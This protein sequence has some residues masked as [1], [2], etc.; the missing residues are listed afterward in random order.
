MS[1]A[2]STSTTLHKCLGCN[3]VFP[4]A[5]NYQDGIAKVPVCPYCSGK[6]RSHLESASA[7][8]NH[9]VG[10]KYSSAAALASLPDYSQDGEQRVIL[11][12]CGGISKGKFLDIG[13]YHPTELS[14]TRAL[15]EIGWSGVMVEP[16]PAPLIT[17]L[18]EY[19]NDPR[20]N[21]ISAVVVAGSDGGL[22]SMSVTDGPYST[23]DQECFQKWS[24]SAGNY[25][26]N[27]LVPMLPLEAVLKV[28]GPFDFID[29]DVE[30]G[31][32]ELFN[33]MLELDV[34]PKCVCVEYDNHRAEIE[35][36]A[37][38]AGYEQVF[39]NAV[40]IIFAR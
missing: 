30:G 35:Q 22:K 1:A 7:S 13:A 8:T 11:Q 26:S 19:G 12:F 36:R 28:L 27:L 21:L 34:K 38:A 24:G 17:L 5:K 25:H 3:G 2:V 15:W 16:S 9:N 4:P 40:N 39:T 37:R 20:V 18:K 33:R 23:I 14:N 29:I 31:S 32:G 10:S 6:G